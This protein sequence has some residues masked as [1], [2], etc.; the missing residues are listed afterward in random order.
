MLRLF[1][2]AIILLFMHYK[3]NRSLVGGTFDRFH[4][5]HQKLLTTAFQNSEK[6]IIG[7]ATDE[8]FKDKS[9]SYIIEDYKTRE[10]TV[11][12]FLSQNNLASRSEIV[13]I[14]D[15]YGTSL[16]DADLDAIFITESNRENVLKMNEE[17]Q[18][19]GF[20]PL[21]I[22]IVAYVHGNDGEIISSVRVRNGEIDR[23][24]NSYVKLFEKQSEFVLP[25]NE[26]G[27]FRK[28]LS[29]IVKEMKD[30]ISRLQ[31]SEMLIAVG[32]IVAESLVKLGRPADVSV[33]DGRTRREILSARS[34]NLFHAMVRLE[35]E[36]PAGVVTQKGVL[37]LK[38]AITNYETTHKKQV[39]IVTGEEDLLAIP[40]ILLSPLQTIVVYGQFDQGI[41]VVNV[42]EQN[43]KRVYNLFRKFK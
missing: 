29:P 38:E 3:F 35:A 17:R 34:S 26:R 1:T 19:K 16:T 8:L 24:G 23:E 39:I 28:P 42:S 31:S 11:L 22:I 12:D 36:N 37:A 43:K 18:K 10:Q 5:G 21:E 14:H 33:I 40:A 41:V 20:R 4:L 9:Q 7:L 15:F 25:G 30:V 2:L 6:V 13:P 32:D 27:E